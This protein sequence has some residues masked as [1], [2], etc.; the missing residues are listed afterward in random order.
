MIFRTK[1]TDENSG[2]N[3]PEE[4]SLEAVD[5]LASEE[6]PTNPLSTWEQDN[7]AAQESVSDPGSMNGGDKAKA[8]QEALQAKLVAASFG[9]IVAILMRSARYRHYSLSDL[10]WLV[11]APVKT[12][13]FVLA[14]A[15]TEK[16]GT[17]IPAGV[18]PV[19]PRVGRG[20]QKAQ[21]Q[22]RSANSPRPS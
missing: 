7:A 5:L 18:G 4:T 13:Q 3:S 8:A 21:R 17:A 12:G 9:D 19:G 6:N 1:K 16:D 15:R 2:N 11:V 14:A 20:R 22:S 10:E